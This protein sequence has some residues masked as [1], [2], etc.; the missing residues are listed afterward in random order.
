MPTI[1]RLI[2]PFRLTKPN[3]RGAISDG[4][5]VLKALKVCRLYRLPQLVQMNHAE[6]L[7]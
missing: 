5:L 7:T 2:G 4:E 6:V 1:S 3:L